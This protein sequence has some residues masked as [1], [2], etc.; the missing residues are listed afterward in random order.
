MSLFR[1]S[2]C[3]GPN[4]TASSAT[5]AIRAHTY[6]GSRAVREP[7][8]YVYSWNEHEL[9]VV[10][11]Y[12]EALEVYEFPVRI[13][14]APNQ[15]RFE[16]CIKEI[17]GPQICQNQAP[18]IFVGYTIM[19][20]DKSKET[21]LP[22]EIDHVAAKLRVIRPS[23]S[24]GTPPGPEIIS[25]ESS[26]PRAVT[27]VRSGQE[28][29]DLYGNTA[30]S[31][32][33][34]NGDISRILDLLKS[35][36]EINAQNSA[37]RTP[38]MQA[39]FWGR[40]KA[41][42]L[43]LG[44]E[45]DIY[46]K[47]IRGRTALALTK[48]SHELDKERRT[49]RP[50]YLEYRE[51]QQH[52]DILRVILQHLV[53]LDKEEIHNATTSVEQKKNQTP[54]QTAGWQDAFQTYRPCAGTAGPI[55]LTAPIATIF[56]KNNLHKRTVAYLFTYD[57]SSPSVMAVSGWLGDSE[58]PNGLLNNK[59]ATEDVKRLCRLWKH[60]LKWHFA[61]DKTGLTGQTSA[62]HV[63]KQL[64]T[65][66]VRHYRYAPFDEVENEKMRN[67]RRFMPTQKLA[68]PVILVSRNP[69]LGCKTF[70]ALIE[71][72]YDVKFDVRRLRN[73]TEEARTIKPQ[74]PGLRSQSR[75]LASI[76]EVEE[77]ETP[78]SEHIR[79]SKADIAQRK[80][81][82]TPSRSHRASIL[83][84]PTLQISTTTGGT[85][86]PALSTPKHHTTWSGRPSIH[87]TPSRPQIQNPPHLSTTQTVPS[88]MPRIPTTPAIPSVEVITPPINQ[89][90][91]R[92]RIPATLITPP[93]E[94]KNRTSSLS[95]TIAAK[96]LAT[97][98]F[99]AQFT[100]PPPLVTPVR[101]SGPSTPLKRAQLNVPRPPNTP[102]PRTASKRS[103]THQAP[104]TTPYRITRSVS[105]LGLITPPDS[106][107]PIVY[108]EHGFAPAVAGKQVKKRKLEELT[109]FE[110]TVEAA[111][112]LAGVVGDR[113]TGTARKVWRGELWGLC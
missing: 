32:A 85:V 66:F 7:P 89:R 5:T 24:R 29:R 13:V 37:G 84:S 59:V 113:E 3:A 8:A 25:L 6:S 17:K 104:R 4:Q 111:A 70:Q 69:C 27:T 48:Q 63:E 77:I 62:C 99:F 10:C 98:E 107:P 43:I 41:A 30:L 54:K 11:P 87:T 2:S 88:S 34:E 14:S 23:M 81:Q 44:H 72:N 26:Y 52:R 95:P 45:P 82:N 83:R 50:G 92:P 21:S 76:V 106:E 67:L 110:A 36:A 94:N 33:A 18:N 39:C 53:D 38:L 28:P 105:V 73:R 55:H 60:R 58:G 101:V 65:Y 35:G 86:A 9:L 61:D 74:R 12:C 71:E 56:T 108:D 15:C 90:Q 75:V 42:Q 22:W 100:L 102:H 112:R 20:Y 19:G 1:S 80:E 49:A 68:S 96:Q 91:F 16:N 64:M 31:L 47:D 109:Q 78:R 79:Q 46:T 93:S 40:I 103:I 57:M 97:K 51:Q